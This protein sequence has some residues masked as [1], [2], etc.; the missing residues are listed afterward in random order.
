MTENRGE[1]RGL[2]LFWQD[3]RGGEEREVGH[4]TTKCASIRKGSNISV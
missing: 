4:K 2:Y 3:G 1:E